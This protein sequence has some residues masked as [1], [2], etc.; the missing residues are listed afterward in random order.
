MALDTVK[1]LD[2][3]QLLKSPEIVRAAI[4][5]TDDSAILQRIILYILLAR[6]PIPEDLQDRARN[7]WPAGEFDQLA[8]HFKKQK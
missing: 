2:Q 5:S 1:A 4:E 3:G 7:A 8:A 6:A